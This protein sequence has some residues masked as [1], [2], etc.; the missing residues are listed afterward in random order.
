MRLINLTCEKCGADLELDL[1]HI[2]AYC[3]YCGN[4][5]MIDVA[6]LDKILLEREKRITAEKELENYKDRTIFD[7]K[8]NIKS[9]LLCLLVCCGGMMF[10]ALAANKDLV[11]SISFGGV[12]GAPAAFWMHKYLFRGGLR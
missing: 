1:D 12:F 10:V 3:P 5:L 4:R 2:T 8:R 6:N 9:I 7:E 11:T